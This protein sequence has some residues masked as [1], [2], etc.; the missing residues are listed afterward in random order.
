MS[1]ARFTPPASSPGC[2]EK[3][4]VEWID[5]ASELYGPEQRGWAIGFNSE[6]Y[7][8]TSY[9]GVAFCP[10]CGRKLPMSKEEAEAML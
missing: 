2:C 5:E 3:E 7:G 10:F 9:V 8:D 4:I 1:D 6:I